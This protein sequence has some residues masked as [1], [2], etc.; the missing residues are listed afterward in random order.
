[1]KA[2]L[3][4]RDPEIRVGDVP[5]LEPGDDEVLVQVGACGIC[6]SEL[7]VARIKDFDLP[8]PFVAGHEAAGVV[9]KVGKAVTNVE[10]G[11]HVAVQPAI[12]CGTCRFCR[13]GHANLCQAPRHIGL[14]RP[15][16]FAEYVAAPAANVH[17]SGDLPDTAAA[18]TEPLACALHGLQR[19]GPGFA[20]DVLVFGAGTIGLL[21]LQ[22]VRN[23]GAGRVVIIDL[24]PHRLA[25]AQHLGADHVVVP[26]EDQAAALRRLAPSGFDCVVDTTGV[27]AVVEAAFDHVGPAGRLLMLGSC[28]TT[29]TISIHPRIVQHQDVTVMGAFSF[30]LEFVPAL[31]MLREGRIQTDPIVTHCY[32]L[33]EFPQAF[34][35]ARLGREGIKICICP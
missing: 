31:Q 30:S 24:H 4:D 1:M 25:A 32:P 3:F 16:G 29:A 35:Q 12:L 11:A 6:A 22:L 10:P 9:A 21:F 17:A 26:D 28:P 15:G 20:E 8:Y 18:C 23:Q 34:E 27:P 14:H 2:V 13:S 19:L 33:D 5:D 7:H